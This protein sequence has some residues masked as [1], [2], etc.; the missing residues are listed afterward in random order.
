MLEYAFQRYFDTSGLF[1]TPERAR[2]MVELL[3]DAGVDEIACLLDFG[4]ATDTVLAHLPHL[5]RV[6]ELSNAAIVAGSPISHDAGQSLA[7]QISAAATT[8]L[9]CTPSMAR[10]L[11]LDPA[12]RDSLGG[13][14]N[15][16]VG[17][18]ALPPDLARELQQVAGGTVTN[19]YGPT[20][21][22]IWSSSWQL[23][24]G[25]DWVPIG[26]PVRIHA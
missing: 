25:L 18:E 11:T 1:G 5:A 12:S 14:P 17:G 9:Q 10:M 7:E 26:T 4:V 20:E 22:T 24:P 19:M 8:H 2:R 3:K 16:Y 15:L 13:V 21:T 23:R 6:R